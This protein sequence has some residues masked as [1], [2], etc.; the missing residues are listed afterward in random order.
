[1]S[2]TTPISLDQSTIKGRKLTSRLQASAT[3]KESIN[4]SL[5]GEFPAVLL[6][7]GATVDNT[8]VGGG[9]GGD[10]LLEPLAD[11]GVDFL[12]LFGGCDLA[13]ADGPVIVSDDLVGLRVHRDVPDGLI[14]NDDLG[15]LLLGELL[16]GGV[17][18]AGY[19]FDGLVCFTLLWSVRL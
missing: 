9:L 10:G 17:E 3:D 14:G 15:P 12:C 8:G 11:S 7:D 18:L 5:L 1:M 19:D 16:G 4:I 6:A 2:T 13:S